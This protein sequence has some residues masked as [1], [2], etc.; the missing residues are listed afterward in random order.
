MPI[1]IKNKDGHLVRYES[2]DRDIGWRTIA[3]YALEL[4]FLVSAFLFIFYGLPVLAT[5]FFGDM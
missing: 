3:R 5:L 4:V 1:Y 2:Y